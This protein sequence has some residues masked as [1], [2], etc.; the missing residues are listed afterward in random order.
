MIKSAKDEDNDVDE[1]NSKEN[2]S[3]SGMDMSDKQQQE[4]IMD[5]KTFC[6]SCGA[7]N[8]LEAQFCS[9]YG[10]KLYI[11]DSASDKPPAK[12]LMEL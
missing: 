2:K 6:N 3:M 7:P 11:E 8:E 4:L 10:N 9:K 5:Q 12:P 1:L